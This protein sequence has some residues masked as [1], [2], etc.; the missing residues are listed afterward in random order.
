[1][2]TPTPEQQ[3]VLGSEARLR[4]VRASPG[5]GKTWLVA[6]LIR[7][8]LDNWQAGGGGIAALSFTR[9]GGEEIHNALGYELGHPHFVG[10]IDAFLFRYVIRPFLRQCFSSL[11]AE[12][13]LI[14]ADWDAQHWRCVAKK[15]DATLA[16]AI[17]LFGCVFID[18]IDRKAVVAYKPHP[19]QPL[20]RIMGKDLDQVREGKTRV[21]QRTGRLTHSDAALWAS[22]V[23][24]HPELGMAV[25][26][27][28]I[29]RF[30]LLI[31]DELQDTGFFLGKSIR[32]L[33]EEEISRGVLVGDPDQAIYEFN[34]ARPDL[35][36]SFENIP[37]SLP[38]SLA[39]SRRCPSSVTACVL[40]L[41]DTAGQIDHRDGDPGRAFL[42]R[43]TAMTTE[44]SR[45]VETIRTQNPSANIKIVAR[46][47]KV[48]E[49]LTSMA[50]K[51]AKSLHCPVLTHMYRAVK[52]FRQGHNVR[53]LA[54]ARSSLE[55]AIFGYEGVP[56]RTILEYK[57]DPQEWKSV[58]I[59]CLLRCNALPTS[60]TLY[61]WQT[62]AGEILDEEV[63]S[64]DL[65]SGLELQ[66]GQLKP[67]KRKGWDSPASDFLPNTELSS[68]IIASVPVQTVHGVK[69]ETHDVTVFVCPDSSKRCPSVIWWSDD[70]K[71]REEKR[72]AYV[73]MTRTRSDLF[74]CVSD[75]CYQRLL[76]ARAEFVSCFDCM[77]IDDWIALPT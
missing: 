9:I 8:E 31:V 19:A 6:E 30:P 67:Q 20:K 32:L 52:A 58:M 37:G 62:A 66:A 28:I 60:T 2:R 48:V 57:I 16:K 11:F 46:Q 72:I 25:R 74:V 5:S 54:N 64:L 3:A 14:P 73:A 40:H 76:R 22:E 38:L 61:D 17:S 47:S 29:R 55:L 65:P 21:W 42:L 75:R 34:G 18:E 45:L 33:L 41:K 23:L 49:E 69:G 68:S 39:R 26:S 50:A 44:V 12:P 10:T 59:R 56:E 77:T 53:G 1:M 71:D 70:E 63:A 15:E 35:F 43:Y 13:R 51:Y 27:E 36:D 7:R 24:A 4:V